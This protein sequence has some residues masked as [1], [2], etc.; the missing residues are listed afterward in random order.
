[1]WTKSNL[2]DLNLVLKSNQ[3][4][5]KIFQMTKIFAQLNIQITTKISMLTKYYTLRIDGVIRNS[6]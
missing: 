2:M 4:D 5:C 3:Q 1:M 6:S